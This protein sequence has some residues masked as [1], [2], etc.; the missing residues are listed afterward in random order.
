MDNNQ[1]KK[2]INK[3]SV[4]NQWEKLSELIQYHNFLYYNKND[5]EISDEEYD[6]LRKETIEIYKKFPEYNF[7]LDVLN[8][9]GE[10]PSTIF[11]KIKHQIPMLSL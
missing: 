7:N 9:I 5:P 8:K 3:D 1:N 6:N 10:K 2:K 11:G 4:I